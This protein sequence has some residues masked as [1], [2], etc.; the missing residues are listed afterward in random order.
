MEK[1]GEHGI[2]FL[3]AYMEPTRNRDAIG[4]FNNRPV[5]IPYKESKR[6]SHGIQILAGIANGSK[7]LHSDISVNQDNQEMAK[8]ILETL[9][10]GNESYR[11]FFNKET[12]LR[13]ADVESDNL[14][15]FGLMP[16]DK[17]MRYRLQQNNDFD[18]V[19]EMLPNN[20]LSTINISIFVNFIK[21]SSKLN[22]K[23]I[24]LIGLT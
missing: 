11:Q 17:N 7:E 9:V 21:S 14:E 19:S 1:M 3:Y 10:Q 22:L 20:P 24:Y 5:T 18:W 13:I 15:L 6:Y 2:N 16:F 8:F 23:S 4:V 12:S